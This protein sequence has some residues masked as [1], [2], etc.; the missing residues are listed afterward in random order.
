MNQH[1]TRKCAAE[2]QV[3]TGTGRV[4][5]WER[6]RD[7]VV[8]PDVEIGYRVA[9]GADSHGRLMVTLELTGTVEL[10]CQRSLHAMP[11]ELGRR[12]NVLLAGDQR[13]LELWDREV[14]DAEVVLADQPID[15]EGLLEDEFLLSLPYAPACDDPACGEKLQRAQGGDAGRATAAETDDANP[16]SVLKRSISKPSH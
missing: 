7:E 14:D 3:A 13:E 1:L 9:G 2:R 10:V 5:D 16:F 6:A 15:L 4:G 8:D 12:T 11:L